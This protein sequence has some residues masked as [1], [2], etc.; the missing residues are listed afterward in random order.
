MI[1]LAEHNNQKIKFLFTQDYK[2]LHNKLTMLLKNHPKLQMFLSIPDINSQKNRWFFE[3]KDYTSADV[4][5]YSQFTDEEKD[6]IIDD[7]ETKIKAMKDVLSKDNELRSMLDRFFKIP[8]LESVFAIKTDNGLETIL[9]QWGCESSEIYSEVSTLSQLIN[10]PRNTTAKVIIETFYVDGSRALDKNFFIEYLGRETKEKSNRD[11]SYDRGRC[12]IGSTFQVYDKVNDK[13][14][15]VHNF[16]V[17]ANQSYKVEFPLFSDAVIK[18]VNQKKKPIQNAKI[19]TTFEGDTQEHLTNLSGSI[20]LKNLEIGKILN[21]LEVNNPTNSQQYTIQKEK[22]QIILVIDQEFFEE[23]D[24]RIINQDEGLESYYPFIVEYNNEK[25]EYNTDENGVF[26]LTDLKEG[27]E[28]TIIDKKNIANIATYRITEGNNDFVLKIKKPEKKFVNVKL[29]NHKNEPMPNIPIDFK[30]NEKD[31]DKDK[32]WEKNVQ[33][34]QNGECSFPYEDFEDKKWV[35]ASVHLPKKNK[36]KN[37]TNNEKIVKKRFLFKDD[38]LDYT[39]KIKKPRNWWW[40][41]LFLLPLLLL[42]RCEKTVYVKV[43]NGANSVGIQNVDISFAYNKAYLYDFKTGRF[44]T[45]DPIKR[46]ATTDKD[47]IAKFDSTKYSIYSLIFKCFSIYEAK[48]IKLTNPC[49]EVEEVKDNYHLL[50]PGS[51]IILKAKPITIPLDFR[52]ID[53]EDGEVLPDAEVEFIANLNGKEYK[54]KAKTNAAGIVLFDNIPACGNINKVNGSLEG[55]KSDELPSNNVRGVLGNINEKRTL[56]LKPVKAK[57][58]FFVVDCQT[59]QPIPDASVTIEIKDKKTITKKTNV[60]GVGKGEYDDTHVTAEIMLSAQKKYYRKGVLNGSYKVKDFIELPKEKRTICLEPLP[61]PIEFK[62]IDEKT[63]KPLVGVKNIV[64]IQNGDQVKTEELISNSNGVFTISEINPGDKVT[65]VSTYPPDY[66]DNNT[67][68]K[69]VDGVSLIKSPVGDRTIPLKPIEIEV[70][71]RTLKSENNTLLSNANLKILVDGA[72][73]SAIVSSGNGEFRVRAFMR[74]T[75]SIVASKPCYGENST[76]IVN[77]LARSLNSSDQSERD[78][79]LEANMV[80]EISK[81]YNSKRSKFNVYIDGVFI[82]RIESG[83]G[84]DNPSLS[85]VSEFFNLK[86]LSSGT[87]EFKLV[88]IITP[89]LE[90]SV[91]GGCSKVKLS[92]LGLEKSLT[93]DNVIIYS[94]VIP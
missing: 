30:Y 62:N 79:P 93:Q 16:E 41:L 19:S 82:R 25:K 86:T 72:P 81:C 69:E 1:T 48:P 45:N 49:Y 78:I 42:I 38:C 9:T 75:I 36:K 24:I 53:V 26:H 58:V 60:N 34:N 35:R 92:C 6:T 76:K 80:A 89:S 39:I 88:K 84:T 18:V 67:K 32:V 47:G 4:L 44:L 12:K 73:Y 57:I 8:S 66:E 2:V 37:N 90:E 22:N 71:F 15:Y 7:I 50:F 77:K 85:R 10:L 43:I 55:Y 14:V 3:S 31:K 52:V 65:I 94:I 91:C 46:K 64:K 83:T 13:P 61:E 20:E 56:K 5:S 68:V 74:S 21:V 11:G 33:M 23:G 28:I 40:L 17:K 27:N 70:I 59:K 54:H 63:K 29:V 87:H 51:T